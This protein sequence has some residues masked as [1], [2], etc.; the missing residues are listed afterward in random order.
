MS[1][2]Q[3]EVKAGHRHEEIAIVGMGCRF[4]GR[5]KSPED[6]WNLLKNGTDAIVE[7]PPERWSLQG[8][9]HPDREQPGKV[10]TRHGGYVDDFDQFDPSFF[11]ISPHEAERM[12]PQQRLL[13][14]VTWEALEQGG[15]QPKDLRGTSTGVYIGAFA[16]DYHAL[17]FSD[18]FQRDASPYTAAGSMMTMISN[19]ISYLFDFRGPSMTIDT[20]CS[21]SLVAVHQACESLR[22][23]ESQMAVAGG[24]LLSFT[25]QY[26]VV[27]SKAGFLSPDGRCQAFDAAANGY[28][29]GEGIGVVVL[30]RLKDA[31]AE[32]DTVQAVIMASGVN[33]D[34]MTVGITVPNPDA[35]EQLIRATLA[36]SGLSPSDVQYVEAHGTGTPVGDPIEAQAVG[37]VYGKERPDHQPLVI[38]SC[39]TNIGHCESAAGV[40]GL[41]KTA[42]ALKHQKI[43]PHLHFQNSNPA[44]PFAEWN[45]HVPTSLEPWPEH[46]GLTVGAVN[47]FGFGGTN[48]HVI[49]RA[50][51]P[52]EQPQQAGGP[53]VSRPSLLP[54]SGRYAEALPMWA[55]AYLQKISGVQGDS[56]PSPSDICFSAGTKRESHSF[57]HALLFESPEELQT[58]LKQAANGECSE[59]II[60]GKKAV[61]EPPKVVFAFSGMGP[62]WWAMGRQLLEREPVFRETVLRC[63]QLFHSL[64]DWSILKEFQ[65]EERESRIQESDIAMTLNFVLQVALLELWRSWGVV[66]DAVVGHSAGEVAAFYGAGVYSLSDALTVVHHRS[67]LLRRLQGRGTMLAVGMPAGVVAGQEGGIG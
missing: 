17:Q 6:F 48:A 44:I 13:L 66:P 31:L 8:F 65:R 25:P 59:R 15:H 35:Q 39:K 23:G 27:E 40:A 62:Q 53:D 4:P 43:P 16:L 38:G 20:A 58:L 52:Y 57:R 26:S 37:A 54:L 3:E 36:K 19:R 55:D 50:P 46:E 42:L 34:G 24:V 5:V 14:H 56:A 61:K 45:L 9:Y 60:S 11:G 10:V 30:K 22:R 28:V 21:S 47:S 12:D 64:G 18:P 32:G 49:V 41:I 29:R 63:D 33:Q 51:E 7:T 1:D 2:T 67:R